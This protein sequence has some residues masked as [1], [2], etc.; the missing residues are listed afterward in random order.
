[1][2]SVV[3][4]TVLKDHQTKALR[5]FLERDVAA[6]LFGLSVLEHWG[7]TGLKD[8]EWWG[9]FDPSDELSAVCY[10][11]TYTPSSGFD[12][13]VPYGDPE[14]LSVL[15]MAL[16]ARGG[17]RWVV[18]D[19][20]SSDAVWDGLGAPRARLCSDQILFEATQASQGPTLDLRIG[21]QHDFAWLHMAA[22]LMVEEDLSL[23]WAGQT[24]EQ[25]AGRLRSSI[26]EGA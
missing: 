22:S 10:A 6:N 14:A 2:V 23:P 9:V 25:F 15:G 12:L 18:G 7:V 1:M 20:I 13:V 26:R 4:A 21:T 11:G 17:A 3:L 16:S 5:S 19:R 24:P 8:A